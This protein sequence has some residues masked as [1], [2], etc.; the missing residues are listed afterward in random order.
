[1]SAFDPECQRCSVQQCRLL[2]KPFIP[3]DAIA[4]VKETLLGPDLTSERNTSQDDNE[5][6]L[7]TMGSNMFP[8]CRRLAVRCGEEYFHRSCG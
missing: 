2:P 1:M 7:S 8:L 6:E 4:L 5:P 3:K